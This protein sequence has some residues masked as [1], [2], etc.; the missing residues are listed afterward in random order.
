MSPPKFYN[1]SYIYTIERKIINTIENSDLQKALVI[2]LKVI[3][4]KKL[5]GVMKR[6]FDN[7]YISFIQLMLRNL[8]NISWYNY[9]TNRLSKTSG[10]SVVYILVIMYT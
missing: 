6:V 10:E 3:G 7:N 1:I 9:K 4:Q 8:Y 2:H 5:S